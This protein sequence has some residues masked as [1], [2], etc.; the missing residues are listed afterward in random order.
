[1]KKLLIVLA[2]FCCIPALAQNMENDTIQL[3]EVLIKNKRPK[4]RQTR[5]TSIC[6][7]YEKLFGKYEMVTLVDD[8]PKGYLQSVTF[9]F[10]KKAS[11]KDKGG[12]EDT[13]IE[14]VFYEVTPQGKPGNRIDHLQKKVLVPGDFSG[15][16][17][18][19]LASIAIR[20]EGKIYIGIKKGEKGDKPNAAFEVNCT[21]GIYDD[22]IS[23]A[24]F[25]E[26]KSW[27]K[28]T[29]TSAFKMRVKVAAD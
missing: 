18:I 16:M 6:T 22:Y 8:L 17:E 7:A 9:T 13:E 15:K 4:I 10:N 20:N 19:D 23:Y 2:V 26:T 29:F 24:R 14:L 21:C 11:R 25:D 1:M 3:K 5:F 27:A 28:K 12:F